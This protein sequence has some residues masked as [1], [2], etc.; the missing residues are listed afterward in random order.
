VHIGILS[1]FRFSDVELT[2]SPGVEAIVSIDSYGVDLLL[3]LLAVCD[4]TVMLQ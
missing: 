2:L 4:D 1:L 3:I